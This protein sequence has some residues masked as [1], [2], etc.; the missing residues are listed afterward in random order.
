[1]NRKRENIWKENGEK[2]EKEVKGKKG[3]VY[4]EREFLKEEDDTQV[5]SRKELVQGK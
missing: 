5:L 4:F 3:N 1:M 2:D